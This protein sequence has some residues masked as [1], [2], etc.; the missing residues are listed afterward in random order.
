MLAKP[1]AKHSRGYFI[2]HVSIDRTLR[3]KVIKQALWMSAAVTLNVGVHV[4]WPCWQD[5][6]VKN[7]I[8]ILVYHECQLNFTLAYIKYVLN[9]A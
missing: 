2:V 3:L 1:G 9:V 6:M 8:H 4:Y 7:N 5:F